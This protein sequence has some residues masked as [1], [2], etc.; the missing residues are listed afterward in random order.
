MAAKK[1]ETEFT[2]AEL[3]IMLVTTKI[4][5]V[6]KDMYLYMNEEEVSTLF[7]N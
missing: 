1:Y 6:I 5:C 3:E 7:V 2:L 4:K